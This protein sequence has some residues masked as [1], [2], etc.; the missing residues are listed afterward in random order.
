MQFILA[1]SNSD[2]V[3]GFLFDQPQA[4]QVGTIRSLLAPVKSYAQLGATVSSPNT[5]LCVN[6][7]GQLIPATQTAGG[8]QPAVIVVAYNIETGVAGNIVEVYPAGI[9]KLY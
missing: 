9:G 1:S 7:K 5:P 6:S 2:L 8:S 3:I 4:G